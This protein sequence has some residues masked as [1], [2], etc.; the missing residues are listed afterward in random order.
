MFNCCLLNGWRFEYGNTYHKT[1]VLQFS[2]CLP[3][4][5]Q[6]SSKED[7]PR[8]FG[9]LFD[10]QKNSVWHSSLESQSPSSAPHGY[11]T[12]QKSSSPNIGT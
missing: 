12:L 1:T 6:Q 3:C 10:P 7:T 2:N 4:G 9:Q 11:S 5:S 8:E